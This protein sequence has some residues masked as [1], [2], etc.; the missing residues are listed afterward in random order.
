M[1][2]F[3]TCDVQQIA[4]G[5]AGFVLPRRHDVCS[6]AE[7]NKIL[8][9][10]RFT[11]DKAG[12]TKESFPSPSRRPLLRGSLMDKLSI[13]LYEKRTVFARARDGQGTVSEF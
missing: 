5:Q 13:V 6:E 3:K 4:V 1:E 12:R 2:L 11:A 9:D 10:L 8:W 7:N